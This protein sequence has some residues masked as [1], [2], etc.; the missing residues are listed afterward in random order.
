MSRK[1]EQ[2]LITVMGIWQ[3]IDGM[4]TIIYYGI[5]QRGNGML[6]L[7]PAVYPNG[8]MM[9][10]TGFGTLLITLGIINLLLSR[11]YIKDDQVYWKIGFFLLFESVLSFIV[12]DL[13]SA[14]LGLTAA[15]LLMAKNKALKVN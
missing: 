4:L 10:I 5:F 2:L 12:L 8:Y 7:S 3:I 14:V 1:Q 13:I 11:R 6:G 9:V 15:I